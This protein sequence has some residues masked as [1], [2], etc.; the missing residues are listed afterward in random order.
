MWR[1]IRLGA[2]F[3]CVAQASLLPHVSTSGTVGPLPQMQSSG[4]R[5]FH[6]SVAPGFTGGLFGQCFERAGEGKDQ[7]G[8][9]PAWSS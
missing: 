4:G 2:G 6:G 1:C 3:P 9:Q 7:P 8:G 5:T